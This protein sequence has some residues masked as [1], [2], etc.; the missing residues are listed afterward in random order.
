MHIGEVD[1]SDLVALLMVARTGR[2]T[3]A[4]DLLDVSHTTVSRRIA[5]L[6]RSLG[7]R[8]L[9]RDATGWS[10]TDLGRTAVAAAEEIESTLARL[11]SDADDALRGSVRIA[12]TEGFS[13][14]VVVPVVARLTR[15]N[16]LLSVDL[17]VV[18]RSVP[19]AYSG[20][21]IEIVVERPTS[22]D[23]E[24]SVLGS[25]RLGLYGS[26]GYLA[27][28]GVPVRREELIG[29]PL[30]YFVGS[31]LTVDAL[32]VAKLDLPAMTDRFRSTSVHV[33][34][35]ATRAGIG[36]GLLPCFLADE[37]DDLTRVLAAEVNAE[38]SY[39]M[40][41]RPDAAR[42]REVAALANALRT[43]VDEIGPALVG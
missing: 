3:A 41:M 35:E 4:A 42:R 13:A 14:R 18:T 30:I 6:E 28:A 20:I 39:W 15:E 8:L 36:L 10:L 40:A 24:A 22:H 9:A 29:R 2:Y 16:P 5:A 32:D 34:V 19:S 17:M 38:M 31:M 23:V 12:A 33:Q 7:G 25:Y 27:A 1:A 21:D 26:T 11:R 37:H 43:R